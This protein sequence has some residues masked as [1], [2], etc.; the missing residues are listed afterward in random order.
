MRIWPWLILAA[1][2]V[3]A[4]TATAQGSPA[5]ASASPYAGVWRS[6]SGGLQ[7]RIDGAGV[8]DAFVTGNGKRVRGQIVASS[9]RGASVLLESGEV[10]TLGPGSAPH[11]LQGAI[12]MRLFV[13]VPLA[14]EQFGRSATAPRG[15]AAAGGGTAGSLAGIKLHRVSTGSNSGSE[16]IYRFCGNGQYRY[17]WQSL[18][19]GSSMGASEE[20]GVW[21]QNGEQVQLQSRAGSK[22]LTLRPIS[23]LRVEVNGRAFSV[24]RSGC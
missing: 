2:L 12:D 8:V 16:T 7:L 24:G 13:L 10:L 17:S 1:W 22:T 4:T 5:P 6:E 14:P 19:G 3:V 9:R 15:E 23:E 20:A 11:T 21:Q 18:S